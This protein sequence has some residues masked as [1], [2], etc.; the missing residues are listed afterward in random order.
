MKA[1]YRIIKN[2]LVYG[3][4]SGLTA[5]GYIYTS[6][7]TPNRYPR[8]QKDDLRA[9]GGDMWKSFGRVRSEETKERQT[10]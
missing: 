8:S 9:I 5:T 3:V 6:K 2:A 4:L 1:K 10:A 7:Y